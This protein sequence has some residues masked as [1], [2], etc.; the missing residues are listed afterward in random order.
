M[1]RPLLYLSCSLLVSSAF[2]QNTQ[3]VYFG[4]YT[5]PTET[6]PTSRSKGIYVSR[7][8][9]DTGALSAPKLAARTTSP[10]F[11]ALHPSGQFLY[12]VGEEPPPLRAHSEVSAYRIK[13]PSGD[14]RLLNR[15]PAGGKGP[16]QIAVE[17][18]GKMAMTA[19]YASGT[20][21]SHSLEKG[22]ALGKVKTALRHVGRGVN[23][24]RQE[25]PHAHSIWPTPDNKYALACDLGVDKVFVYKMNPADGTLSEHG[26]VSLPPGSGPRHLAFHPNG[27]FVFVNNEMLMTV[28]TFAYDAKKGALKLLRTVSTLPKADRN[29]TG[30]STAETVVHPNG[31]FVY[32]SNRTHDTIAVFRCDPQSGKLTLIQNAPTE[33]R[34]PRNF[35]LDRTG[36]WMVVAHQDSNTAAVFSVDP[37]RGKLRFTGTKVSLDSPVCVRFLAL[38]P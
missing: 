27:R 21:A 38:Q 5:S 10:S 26:K 17:P 19:Q 11:V 29:R 30:L 37:V 31:R 2:A 34:I 3:L 12:V 24:E 23:E 35:S 33:G 13:L 20:V 4:T 16:C 7:F 25:G 22:G 36:K 8:D 9:A 28:S 32:V 18:E 6:N 15:V 14:L 1:I